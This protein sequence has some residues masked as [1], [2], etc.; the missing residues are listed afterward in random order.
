MCVGVSMCVYDPPLS[1]T[2]VVPRGERPGDTAA[3]LAGVRA[4]VCVCVCVCVRV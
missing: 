2:T 4:F 3:D 1:P